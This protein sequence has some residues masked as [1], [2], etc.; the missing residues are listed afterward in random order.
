MVK[1]EDFTNTELKA[2]A[3][4]YNKVAKI[5]GYSKLKKD[6]L[7]KKIR[8]HPNL[9]VSETEKGVK[10][11]V[12][13]SDLGNVDK[14]IKEKKPRKKKEETKKKE[15]PKKKEPE[16]KETS[17]ERFERKTKGMT[18][19]QLKNY[20]QGN[21]GLYG[22]DVS[23]KEIDEAKK[24]S[25]IKEKQLIKELT[26]FFNEGGSYSKSKIIKSKKDLIT[27]QERLIG[28]DFKNT[29][30]Y[31]KMV[32][33]IVGMVKQKEEPKKKEAQ[34]TDTKFDKLKESWIKSMSWLDEFDEDKLVIKFK[35][36]TQEQIEKMI[37]NIFKKVGEE[38]KKTNVKM[39]EMNKELPKDNKKI[40]NKVF[41]I[42]KDYE[43]TI[44]FIQTGIQ[45]AINEVM[46]KK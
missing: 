32:K 40:V 45:N 26:K 4:K 27:Y 31:K 9:N 36:K 13:G 18:P 6:E 7:I 33:K 22:V 44:K 20:Q 2:I 5:A 1:L 43:K 42:K 10:I 38:Q 35:G 34:K 8:G 30:L 29:E 37:S 41:K 39:N 15:D 23:Q 14:I 12:V 3:R 21:Q 19:T 28:T 16:K 24:S 46:K 25:D 11:K 17:Q